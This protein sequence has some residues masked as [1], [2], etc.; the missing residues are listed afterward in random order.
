MEFPA[1]VDLL[2]LDREVNASASAP[3]SAATG[4]Q[5]SSADACSEPRLLA[6]GCT[7]A[8]LLAA[9]FDQSPV[10][11]VVTDPSGYI[12]YVN[13]QFT[14]LT[15]YTPEDVIGKSPGVL[16]SGMTPRQTYAELWATIPGGVWRGEFINRKKSGEL[17]YELATIGPVRDSSGRVAHFLAVKQD[18]TEQKRFQR[19][20]ERLRLAAR[21]GSDVIY[22]LDAPTFE[23]TVFS[24]MR[25]EWDVPGVPQ[26]KDEWLATIHPDD[27]ARVEHL[28]RRSFE[29]GQPF[30]AEYR[31]RRKGGDYNVW[32]NRAL[33]VR[34]E[35]GAVVKW[36]GVLVN[37]NRERA[38]QRRLADLAARLQQ[39]N[40]EL[41]DALRQANVATEMK[42]RFLANMS[43]EI[44][45]P[46][47]GIIGTAEMLLSLDATAEQR[48]CAEV[49]RDCGL[50]L[51]TV[52]NDVL[53]M[54]KL[55]AGKM[56][57]EH[58]P[59]QPDRTVREVIHLMHPLAEVKGLTLDLVIGLDLPPRALGDPARVT[60]VLNN[61][62]SNAIKFTHAGGVTV[63]LNTQDRGGRKMLEYSVTDTGMGVPADK[64]ETIFDCFVQ[65]DASA[66]RRFGGTGL[67]LAICR[68][69]AHLM[70]GEIRLT[71]RPGQGSTFTLQLPFDRAESDCVDP[72]R[73][74]ATAG[75]GRPRA[76][77]IL[78]V[79]DNLVN[80][81]IVSKLLE[82]AGQRV[83]VA[84][85]GLEAL[86]AARDS[87][88]DLILMDVQ[89]P[90]M[91]GIEA[92][93]RIREGA[94]GGANGVPIVALTANAMPGDREAYLAAGMSDYLAK[95]ISYAK[96]LDKLS[97]WLG[98][99][100]NDLRDN[101]TSVPSDRKRSGGGVPSAHR[102]P[103]RSGR[104][105]HPRAAQTVLV[106]RN[107]R[108]GCVP[109]REAIEAGPA[110]H[111]AATRV[112]TSRR[113]RH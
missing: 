100:P 90:E 77:K 58:L 4:P 5:P 9:M 73:F 40:D 57:I 41:N 83:T 112:R 79:E 30:H 53:D 64:Q 59:Y 43:H 22:E 94:N 51:L 109:T 3:R 107:G 93:R 52:L 42:G 67:G 61:L 12:E 47:N 26:T 99:A 21:L 60:Q 92:A 36:V 15:G 96:L 111:R 17:F 65:A 28:F 81:R 103:L 106:R 69:L 110:R 80:Q 45:T 10:S 63:R 88:F 25:H 75:N 29:S 72:S 35:T 50:S 82:H 37:M 87:R 11:I 16:N 105:L 71:S 24:P 46:L 23:I 101:K 86:A 85:N 91:D 38:A 32:S 27:L 98:A 8:A 33:P 62:V 14:E 108:A 78:L 66:S 84:G 56:T 18:I 89:M 55:E 19:V 68:Q 13:R 97:Q 95:P 7:D 113:A 2:S 70:G 39:K 6:G 49:I 54:S 74:R 44:R 104:S 31:T 34:D 76:A 1:A 102:Q 48:D 20:A